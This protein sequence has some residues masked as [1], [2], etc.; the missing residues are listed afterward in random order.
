MIGNIEQQPEATFRAPHFMISHGSV[1][2]PCL[3]YGCVF[4]C[5]FSSALRRGSGDLTGG[6]DT[7]ESALTSTLLGVRC[8]RLAIP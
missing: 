7:R 2:V 8:F 5:L 1:N 6:N 4:F 3:Q